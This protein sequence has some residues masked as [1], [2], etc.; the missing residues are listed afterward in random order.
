[1]DQQ[2]KPKV[3]L[4]V[5][6]GYLRSGTSA[7]L[8]RVGFQGTRGAGGGQR[9]ARLGCAALVWMDRCQFLPLLHSSPLTADDQISPSPRRWEGCQCCS[10]GFP[11]TPNP[12]FSRAR[13]TPL[14]AAMH[15]PCPAACPRSHILCTSAISLPWS[16]QSKHI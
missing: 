1:M 12:G 4:Q 3:S 2:C 13:L 5:I 16:P 8:N 14:C 6:R 7:R 15:A 10:Q 9:P 11:R